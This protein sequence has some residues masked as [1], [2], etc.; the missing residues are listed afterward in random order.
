M[1]T[2]LEERG[3]GVRPVVGPLVEELFLRL[4]YAKPIN[5]ICTYHTNVH[6]EQGISIYDNIFVSLITLRPSIG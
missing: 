2:K 4:P 6:Q 5:D 1:T 3:G